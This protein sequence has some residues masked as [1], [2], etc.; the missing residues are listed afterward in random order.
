MK[1]LYVEDHYSQSELMKQRLE[2]AGY[3]VALAS[4]GE[5]GI[6]KTHEWQPDIILM[7]LRLPGMG[8]VEAIKQLKSDPAVSTIPIIVISAWTTRGFREG[9][10]QA[11]A[12]TFIA[13]PFDFSRLIDQINQWGKEDQREGP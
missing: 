3:E 13:K 12:A 8:G 1:I 9:A 7:D 4:S 6:Q 11:G 5:E 10:L 2:L